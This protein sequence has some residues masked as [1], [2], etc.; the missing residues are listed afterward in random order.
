M[1]W[2]WVGVVWGLG[3]VI[4]LLTM[5]VVRLTAIAI[6]AFQ[7]PFD[8][9]QWS[10][11]IAH[12]AFMAHSEGY[13]GFQKSY[14]PRLVARARHLVAAP[15]P[16]RIALAPLFCMGY[17]HATRR[18]LLSTY[19]LTVAIVVLIVVY[20]GLAQPWRGLLDFGV[21]VGLTWG[22]ASILAF[23]VKALRRNDFDFS[24]ELPQ[25]R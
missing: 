14:A 17:F 19:L 15:T 13:K 16:A 21:V 18:R 12:T 3:G 1:K 22:I 9:W 4:A 7:Y 5:A 11:L 8:G 10:V 6:D 24:P 2:G 23:C 20:H 25:T